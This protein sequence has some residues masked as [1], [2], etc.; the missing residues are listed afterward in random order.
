M[1][2]L[3]RYVRLEAP[4]IGGARAVILAPL[5]R[6]QC[7]SV[8]LA[9][10]SPLRPYWLIC[11]LPGSHETWELPWVLLGGP[12]GSY[13]WFWVLI[14][15]QAPLPSTSNPL[16]RICSRPRGCRPLKNRLRFGLH[17][18]RLCFGLRGKKSASP[19]RW[20]RWSWQ[21]RVS[22]KAPKIAQLE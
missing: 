21:T 10:L 5:C 14:G 6:L 16:L 9:L 17:E 11:A 2:A 8:P 12:L 7:S 22:Q 3:R 20:R 15:L 1:A 19:L 18:A 4:G 13:Q